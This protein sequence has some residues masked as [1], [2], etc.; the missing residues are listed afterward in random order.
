MI[1][2]LIQ[3][4]NEQ[5]SI[6]E[7]LGSKEKFWL[8]PEAKLFKEGRPGTGENWAEVI[9]AEICNLL[10]IPHAK[11]EFAQY[12]DRYGVLTDSIVP[13][14]CALILG[15]EILAFKKETG[16]NEYKRIEYTIENVLYHF[17]LFENKRLSVKLP[18]LN[19]SIS[20]YIK[21]PLDLFIGYLLL[22]A[23]IGNTDRHAENWGLIITLEKR[24]YLAPTF[25]HA[26]SLGRELTDDMRHYKL[27]THDSRVDILAYAKKGK[28]SFFD[29]ERKKRISMLEA[30]SRAKNMSKYAANFW[31]TKLDNNIKESNII[32][33]CNKISDQNL[34]S[35]VSKE[36]MTKLLLINKQRIL[37]GG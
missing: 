36:F 30:F 34:M 27:T 7:Q 13:K 32:K 33:I 37:T 15:N 6:I 10:D 31:L 26:S 20:K 23:L 4:P 9:S 19:D 12:R 35:D 11:Y 16:K 24:I 8:M 17:R 28:S 5:D 2:H 1:Y 18:T 25:D 29:T 22:D 3:I 14:D 21:T